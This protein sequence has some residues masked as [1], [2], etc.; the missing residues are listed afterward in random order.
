VTGMPNQ[1]LGPSWSERIVRLRLGIAAHDALGR[2]G[3]LGGL[4][5]YLEDVPRP[6]QVP[7]DPGVPPGDDAG[8]PGIPSNPSG[9]FALRFG[10][11]GVTARA[12]I[13]VRVVD[14]QRRYVPRRFSVPAPDQPS[15]M[16]ADEANALDPALPLIPRAF[17]P[18]LFPGAAYGAAA[19]AT[20]LRGVV[21]AAG[22]SKPVPWARVEACTAQPIDVVDDNGNVV[23]IQPV[24]GRAHGDDRGEFLLVVGSLPRD[25]VVTSVT[26]DIELEVRVRARPQPVQFQ[27][28]DSPLGSPSDPLWQLPIELVPNLDPDGGV[29][30]GVAD[31]PGYTAKVSQVLTCRRGAATRP[32]IPFIVS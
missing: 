4:G 27:T 17:R 32:V 29:T 11:T 13:V 23:P 28:P 20:V 10:G 8:L 24:L 15:V 3:T 25:V 9:R 16:A 1:I 19:G 12:S 30:L 22:T 31:P 6:W 2:P 14:R 21:L 26:P 7:K 5:L 18:A